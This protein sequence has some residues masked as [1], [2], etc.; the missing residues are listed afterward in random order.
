MLY[1]LLQIATISCSE[2]AKFRFKNHVSNLCK[3]ASQKLHALA[4]VSKYMERSKLELTLTSFVMPHFNYCPLVWIFYDRKPYKKINKIHERVLRIIHKVI[5][6]N[7]E[8]LLIKSN[9]VSFR[10]RDLQ[11]L[12]IEIYKIIS[13][14]NPSCMAEVVVTNFVPYNLCAITNLV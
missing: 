10:Q 14:F 5:T 3:K 2:N 9:S 4:R 13:N 7:F 8:G 11:L 12:L 1:S 6:S